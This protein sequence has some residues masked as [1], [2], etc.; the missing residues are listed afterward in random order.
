MQEQRPDFPHAQAQIQNIKRKRTGQEDKI[1]IGA[2]TQSEALAFNGGD[3]QAIFKHCFEALDNVA[4]DKRAQEKG[5][6]LSACLVQGNEVTFA[7]VGDSPGFVIYLEE[8]TGKVELETLYEPNSLHSLE[9]PKEKIRVEEAGAIIYPGINRFQARDAKKNIEVT[10]AIG[11]HAQA[12][13][14]IATPE[15]KTQRIAARPGK[16]AFVM[17]TSDGIHSESKEPQNVKALV[18]KA[19]TQL[20][21]PLSSFQRLLAN[22]LPTAF[23]NVLKSI[24][25]MR[26]PLSTEEVL[27]KLPGTLVKLAQKS[28]KEGGGGANDDC[29]VVITP[30]EPCSTVMKVLAVADGHG[31]GKISKMIS[32][33]FMECLRSSLTAKKEAR[34]EDSIPAPTSSLV[35]PRPASRPKPRIRISTPDPAA[36]PA[37]NFSDDKK[38]SSTIKDKQFYLQEEPISTVE[39][40]AEQIKLDIPTSRPRF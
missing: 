31:G 36:L 8:G 9:N 21:P 1:V 5:S 38:S 3:K 15:V 40:N 14:M 26:Q 39:N 34:K 33:R 37:S 2:L 7:Y 4:R 28:L 23:Q 16:V 12:P 35:A 27:E 24:G 6:T 18:E 22:M 13:A 32:E 11:D 19:V 17:L 25:V 10:R 30:I 20:N 29:S